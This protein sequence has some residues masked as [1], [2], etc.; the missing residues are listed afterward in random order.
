MTSGWSRYG[1]LGALAVG[2]W[3]RLGAL[4][5]ESLWLDELF[6]V[7][8]ALREDWTGVLD[9]VRQDVHPPGYFL[10]L[11]LLAGLHPSDALWRL[12]SACA[13]LVTIAAAAAVARRLAG[14]A[15]GVGAAWLVAT[16]PG[17]VLL[18]REARGNALLAAAATGLLWLGAVPGG[19]AVVVTG[20]VAAAAVQVHYFGVFAVSLAG[21][22]TVA[23][24][25]DRRL[26]RLAALTL[27]AATIVPWLVVTA[28]GQ[29]EGLRSGGW[30]TVPSADS[31]GWILGELCDDRVGL[32]VLV[33][34]GAALSLDR[35]R[36]AAAPVLLA[37]A[38]VA[39]ILVPQAV[40][41]A[42]TPLLR[43]RSALPVLPVLLLVGAVGYGRAGAGGAAFVALLAVAQ[44]VVSWRDTRLDTRMEQW[45]E[46]AALVPEDASL[47]VANHPWLWRWYLPERVWPLDADAPGVDGAPEAWVLQ[48]H[49]LDPAPALV[50][51]LDGA[52]VA[53]DR[54]FFGA[55]VRHVTSVAPLLP[56]TEPA[57]HEGWSPTEDGGAELWAD[58][59]VTTAVLHARG[60][61]AVELTASE[62][63]AGDEPAR[64][65]VE[66]VGPS[67]ALVDSVLALRPEPTTQRTPVATGP[68]DGVD[69]RVRIGFLNDAVVAGRDRNV[70]VLGVRLRCV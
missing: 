66:L 38:L 37:G 11:H 6:S 47:V 70:H 35:E 67:G 3:L 4:T 58:T 5:R 33:V 63:P 10:F 19:A 51:L 25:P 26:A 54:A 56:L 22:W 50:R 23:V 32:A 18:D 16:A 21:A 65:H 8:A 49:D 60:R 39:Y 29:V 48:A 7:R 44:A 45:R 36:P 57:S 46:A 20:F 61:C 31:L 30:Y 34:L 27:G 64:V 42:L 9:E 55:R 12:P 41:Y 59:S 24:A 62:D 2:A 1:L 43:S 68:V 40:S 53:E 17:L 15:V 14:P 69:V 13:G 28:G 52:T